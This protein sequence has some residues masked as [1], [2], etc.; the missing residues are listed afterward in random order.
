MWKYSCGGPLTCGNTKTFLEDAFR[1]VRQQARP[2]GYTIDRYLRMQHLSISGM[3]RAKEHEMPLVQ[4]PQH[5]LA[6]AQVRLPKKA[7]STAAF[8]PPTNPQKIE[9]M[10]RGQA[11]DVGL[12]A[13]GVQPLIDLSELMGISSATRL[14]NLPGKVAAQKRARGRGRGRGRGRPAAQSQIPGLDLGA[15]GEP[16][17]GGTGAD[18]TGP[19]FDGPGHGRAHGPDGPDHTAKLSAGDAAQQWTRERAQVW[20]AAGSMSQQRSVAAVAL[21]CSL[22][23]LS[24]QD[25]EQAAG[26]A[27]RTALLGRGLF[28]REDDPDRDQCVFMSLGC[29][30]HAALAWALE[31]DGAYLRLS[32]TMGLKWIFGHDLATG[33]VKGLK[34]DLLVSAS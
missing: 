13:D 17:P 28:F 19:G 32:Q 22:R 21:A 31:P 23:D 14:K 30:G 3:R 9:A 27:W 20:R 2:S 26:E 12:P 4:V 7:M 10:D 5:S 6:M 25:A 33:H 11:F 34:V 18:G 1:D 8:T 24:P 29:A 15:T 16:G